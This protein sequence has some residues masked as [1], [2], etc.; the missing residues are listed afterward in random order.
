MIFHV[1]IKYAIVLTFEHV[2]L[3]GKVVQVQAKAIATWGLAM[4][5]VSNKYQVILIY[6][7]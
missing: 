1:S 4:F 7:N 5:S 6:R 3:P 2:I